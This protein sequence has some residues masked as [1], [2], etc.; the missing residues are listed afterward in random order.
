M[1]FW[2]ED[3]AR[4]LILS[5]GRSFVATDEVAGSFLTGQAW[6]TLGKRKHVA[7]STEVAELQR[8]LQYKRQFGAYALI[9]LE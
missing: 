4:D 2:I 1:L 3:L 5:H 9:D 7:T 8:A 6:L